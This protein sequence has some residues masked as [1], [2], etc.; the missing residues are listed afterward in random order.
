MI[1]LIHRAGELTPQSFNA[2]D[3]SV[4]LI[5]TT[6]AKVRRMKF[7]W[8]DG[9]QEFDEE[10]VVSANAVR[11]DRL[12]SGA[13]LLDTHGQWSLSNVIGSVVPGSAKLQRG[14][15]I[16]RV[17]LSRAE[18]DAATVQKIADGIIRNVSVG[19]KIHRVERIE[20]DGQ[21][22]LVRVV[23]WEPMEISA[24]PIGADAGAA[25]RAYAE[26]QYPLIDFSRGGGTRD[27]PRDAKP[28]ID[29]ILARMRMR[30]AG[31]RGVA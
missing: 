5:W 9:A 30:E 21:M 4:D 20:Q 24:V 27:I 29:A 11:L 14:K 19:Y 31:L 16:A 22:P 7:T 8:N 28:V 18:A 17:Q 2:A 10:L 3:N 1:D 13:P 15:G 12:N 25:F 26:G 23:D 6:G